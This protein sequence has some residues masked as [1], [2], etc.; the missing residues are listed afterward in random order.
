M[1][2][3]FS[4]GKPV[5]ETLQ[6]MIDGRVQVSDIPRIQVTV[7]TDGRFVSMC[8][9]RLF[10]FKALRD[11]GLITTIPVDIVPAKSGHMKKLSTQ[12][13]SHKGKLCLK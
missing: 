11:R 7:T 6:E 5:E 2:R 1:S 9:R 8:N 4:T 12:Q 13:L 3:K 10:V